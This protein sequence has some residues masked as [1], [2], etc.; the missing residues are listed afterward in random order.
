[1][2][3]RQSAFDQ[4]IRAAIADM[5]LYGFDS[6]ARVQR[7]TTAIRQAAIALM[8]PE[9]QAEQQLRETL[10]STYSKFFDGGEMRAGVFKVHK[11]IPPFTV[12]R[13][14]PQT[15]LVLDRYIMSAA[16]LIKLN[17]EQ[18]I[19]KTLQRF[20]GWSTSIP[21]GGS[22][23]VDKRDTKSELRKALASLPYEERRVNIDQGHKLISAVSEV[24]A[25]DGG[26]LAGVWHSHWKQV[27]YNYR[28]D[29][30]ERDLLVYA[31]RGNWAMQK[32]LMKV[33]PAG[34]T[35]QIT[36]PSEEVFCRCFYQW[37]YNLTDLPSDML[38]AKGRAAL[39]GLS[40]VA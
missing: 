25:Q 22:K 9:A 35:D 20:T 34:Y 26:A 15:R 29:H 28:E 5:S 31:V 2:P 38:T 37:L 13:L 3:S 11:G 18:A 14:R 23:V 7:W 4:V 6:M 1:M 39:N 40:L 12:E 10:V 19:E 33:G 8:I 36:K 30:K 17:R 21:A 24:I 32:G 27:G 16:N